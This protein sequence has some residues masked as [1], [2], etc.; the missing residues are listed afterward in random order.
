MQA[1]SMMLKHAKDHIPF[2]KDQ[3]MADLMGATKGAQSIQSF[4][5]PMPNGGVITFAA[6]NVENMADGN[7]L[8]LIHNHTGSVQGTVDPASRTAAQF[9]VVGPTDD[10]VLDIVVVGT[11]IGQVS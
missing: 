5:I 6:G 4:Q 3:G 8:V 2:C 10:D 11:V 9:T 1:A 7:Y